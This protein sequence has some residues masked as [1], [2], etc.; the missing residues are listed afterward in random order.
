MTATP[1]TED[2]HAGPALLRSSRAMALGTIAS[3]GTGFLRTAV[4]AAALGTA[5]LSSDYNLAN[6]IPNIIYELLLGGVL[7]SV[8]VPL[9]VRGE[10]E[11]PR[12]GNVYAQRL[13]TLVALVLAV[14]TVLSVFGAPLIMDV[15]V[16]GGSPADKQVTVEFARLLLPQIFFYGVGAM[17][18]AILNTRGRFAAPMWAPVLNNLVVIAVGLAFMAVTEGHPTP[19]N[20]P[21][22]ATLLLGIG[23]TVGIV[24]QTAALWP[25]LRG[26]GFRWRPRFDFLGVGL[27]SVG[28]VAV[29]VL[30]YVVT[31]QVGYLV[32]VRLAK[33]AEHAAGL[34]G[35][36]YASFA[37]YVFAFMLFSL[38][39]AVVAVSVI[40]ALLPR[41]SNHAA[42]GRLDLLRSDLSA[43]LRL[44]GV[45]IVPSSL[46]LIV[47]GQ[48]IAVVVLGHGRTTVQGAEYVGI[49][50]AAYAV[51]LVPFSCFQ[52]L[53]RA[54]YA[55]QDTRTPALLN[56]WATAANI[57]ADVILYFALPVRLRVVGLALGYSLSYAVGLALLAGSLSRRIGG[58]DGYRIIRS[59]V[60][61][62]VAAFIGA[63]IARA[64]A[65]AVHASV[66]RAFGGALLAI[67]IGGGVG[68]LAFVWLAR[69][70]RVS[71]LRDVLGLV[72]AAQGRT[73]GRRHSQV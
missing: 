62:G 5:A 38:P 21:H 33:A 47:L 10:R 51:G 49:V 43:G 28:I 19:G 35:A 55:L 32:S 41:M 73:T 11:D 7:T 4:I 39:H 1:A 40:T 63:L 31:N 20:V 64:L 16:G 67:V 26:S 12:G 66:G 29:W 54:F 46:A 61:L 9:L 17:V 56:L 25:S 71:E 58:L 45:L 72:R 48:E 18:G 68:G 13:L 57:V 44:S 8:V 30:V 34:Q 52:L 37:A 59:Y 42:D 27:R 65:I 22:G 69:R 15:Y 60:R 2:P 70:M 6:T 50:L 36:P 53:L 14:L 23:T 3:R 24:V